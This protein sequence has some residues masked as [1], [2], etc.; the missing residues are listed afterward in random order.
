MRNWNDEEIERAIETER[1]NQGITPD[2]ED[3]YDAEIEEI[4]FRIRT[5]AANQKDNLFQPL[6]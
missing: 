2:N 5:N 1:A 3:R 6:H 4:E